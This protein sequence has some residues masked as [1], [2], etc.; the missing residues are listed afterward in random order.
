MAK[1]AITLDLEPRWID[2]APYFIDLLED[3][4]ASKQAKELA[5][6]EIMKMARA[7]TQMR[8]EQKKAEKTSITYE[9]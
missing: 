4:R 1:E 5:R 6:S 3:N 8:A 9:W 2:I 7:C